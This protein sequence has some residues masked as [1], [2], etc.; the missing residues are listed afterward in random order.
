VDHRTV[1]AAFE[2]QI[3]LVLQ[4][5]VGVGGFLAWWEA[6][7]APRLLGRLTPQNDPAGRDAVDRTRAAVHDRRA[8]RIGDAELIWRL[9][10]VLEELRG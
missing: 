8:G 4:G 7:D 5:T 9:R 6:N 2:R 10:L 3:G 1:R